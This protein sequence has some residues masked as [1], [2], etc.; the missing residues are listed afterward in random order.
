MTRVAIESLIKINPN[1]IHKKN[2]RFKSKEWIDSNENKNLQK[3][4]IENLHTIKIAKLIFQ[5]VSESSEN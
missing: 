2:N 4:C 3:I 5:F 1:S